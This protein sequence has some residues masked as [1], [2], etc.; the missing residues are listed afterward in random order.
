MFIP[1]SETQREFVELMRDGWHLATI[2]GSQTVPVLYRA[3]EA[4]VF[5]RDLFG[6]MRHCG[7]L[8][9]TKNLGEG[10]YLWELVEDQVEGI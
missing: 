7:A 5:S 4:R 8:R 3:G 9:E 6:L 2:G 1:I 10:I